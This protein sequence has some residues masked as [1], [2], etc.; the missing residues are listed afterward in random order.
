MH[1]INRAQR[2]SSRAIEPAS[3]N[4]FAAKVM[5]RFMRETHKPVPRQVIN[6]SSKFAVRLL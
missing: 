2:Q 3:E 6:F 4:A 5:D 1:R